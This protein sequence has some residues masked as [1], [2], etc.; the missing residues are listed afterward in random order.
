[1]ALWLIENF[2]KQLQRTCEEQ[3]TACHFFRFDQLNYN[4]GGLMNCRIS[5]KRI[6]SLALSWPTKPLPTAFAM[7][8]SRRPNPTIR[9]Q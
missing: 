3:S 4:A 7:P 8:L 1:V 6:T 9:S 2:A 5:L